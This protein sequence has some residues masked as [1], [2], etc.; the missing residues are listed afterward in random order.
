MISN[1]SGQG[2]DQFVYV[3]CTRAE[4]AKEGDEVLQ[5]RSDVRGPSKSDDL[6]VATEGSVD[7]REET[8]GRREDDRRVSQFSNESLQTLQR[9]RFTPEDLVRLRDVGRGLCLW[10]ADGALDPIKEEPN[11]LLLGGEVTIALS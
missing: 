4:D 2:G 10:Q 1:I 8:S 9:D 3:R 5:G 7:R 11:H 6:W